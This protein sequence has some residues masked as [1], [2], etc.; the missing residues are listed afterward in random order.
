MIWLG[1]VVVVS[2]E[3]CKGVLCEWLFVCSLQG[4]ASSTHPSTTLLLERRECRHQCRLHP[5]SLQPLFAT[6]LWCAAELQKAEVQC[7]V[8][9][10][11]G[12][13]EKGVQKCVKHGQGVEDAVLV[14]INRVLK[15][16]QSRKVSTQQKQQLRLLTRLKHC[17]ARS[18]TSR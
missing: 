10:T 1:L 11:S 12:H 6:L 5:A 15:R 17:R 9:P 4:Q 2:S 14:Q 18:S 7:R 16:E 8:Q 13:E 3:T